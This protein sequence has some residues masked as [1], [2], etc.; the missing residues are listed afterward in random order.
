MYGKG[1]GRRERD[2]CLIPIM[3]FLKAH[4][5]GRGGDELGSEVAP[6]KVTH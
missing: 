6:V 1:E 4:L 5:G 3:S 2:G